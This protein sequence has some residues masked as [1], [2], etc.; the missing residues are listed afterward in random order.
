MPTS[1]VTEVDRVVDILLMIAEVSM[2]TEPLA[3]LQPR[4]IYAHIRDCLLTA[5]GQ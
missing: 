5:L 4:Q 3:C 2:L 1:V